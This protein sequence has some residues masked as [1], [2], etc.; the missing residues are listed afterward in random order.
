MM[1]KQ[2]GIDP[3]RLTAAQVPDLLDKLGPT[4]RTL[5]GK[6]GAEKVSAQIIE[7]LSR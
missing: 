7:E 4:L 2:L 6:A 5:L 3:D 1:A